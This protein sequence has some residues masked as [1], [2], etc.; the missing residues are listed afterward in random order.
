MGV[1]YLVLFFLVFINNVRAQNTNPFE[2]KNRKEAQI[3]ENKTDNTPKK[4]FEIKSPIVQKQK[5]ENNPFEINKIKSTIVKE[6]QSEQ[7]ITIKGKKEK[8]TDKVLNSYKKG[9]KDNS[10]FLLWVFLFTLV[11]I[12]LLL[13]LNRLLVLKII[14][15]LWFYNLTNILFRNFVSREYM[16]YLFLF[17]NFI[18]NFSIFV[19]L[20]LNK[21]FQFSGFHFFTIIFFIILLIYIFKHL[22]IYLFRLIFPTLKNISTY[23]FSVLLFNISLGIFLLPLNL[24]IAYSF[25]S[26]SVIFIYFSAILIGLTYFLR[27]LR[28]FLITYNYIDISIVHFFLYLCAFEIL[29][30]FI[31]YKLVVNYL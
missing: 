5:E 21:Y 17:I 29:P 24:F 15:S 4:D 14:K 30:L 25:D 20:F 16:Y 23:N 11:F 3:P 6:K 28:G 9:Q 22:F 31:F 19:Y 18:L 26:L 8:V 10:S 1:K 12:A 2:I 27:L 7:K 13:S